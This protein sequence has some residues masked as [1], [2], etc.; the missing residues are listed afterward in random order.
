M[1]EDLKELFCDLLD[2]NQTC[3]NSV[4]NNTVQNILN[5]QYLGMAIY[6]DMLD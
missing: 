2:A 4:L 1:D 3:L 6:T 5:I